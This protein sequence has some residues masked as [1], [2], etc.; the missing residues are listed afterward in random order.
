MRSFSPPEWLV[1]WL[2]P[3]LAV[4]AEGALL[5]VIY[6]AIET[7]V[8][9]RVPLLGTFEFAVAAGLAAVTVRRGWIDPDASVMPFLGLLL[10]L[11]VIGW[12]WDASVR[13]LV[14]AGDLA[15]AITRHPG[16]WL[17]VVAGMRGIGRGL[18]IDDRAL[19]RL[20]LV[21]VP[22]LA[23]PWTFGQVASGELRPVFT[24]HAFIAS[25]TFVTTGFIAAG[26][27]RL[28]EIGRETGVDW[29]TNR[30]WL[31]TVFGVLVVVLALGYPAAL[32]LGLPGDAVARGVLEP[33]LS[34]FG[35]ALAIIAGT[36]LFVAALLA[37]MLRQAGLSFQ[38]GEP[39][40]PAAVLEQ[41]PAYTIEQ[42]RGP[43]I[44]VVALWL[45]VLVVGLVL[46]RVWLRRRARSRSH[47]T[48]EERSF[49]IPR[50]S[51]R[52]RRGRPSPV[53]RATLRGPRPTDA[54]TA[55][56]AALQDLAATAPGR[57]R[58]EH[59]TPRAHARR[60]MAGSELD[61]LQADYALARYGE[62]RLT[63]AENR[64]AVGR[65]RRLRGRL[66]TQA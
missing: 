38:P 58:A 49:Q 59:E 21:G 53:L 26:L 55:Y 36:A 54:V 5:G 11:G 63:D 30:S 15:G 65:W 66:R 7:T 20:V 13:E 64:R 37:S 52:V 2:L 6:V 4:V 46:V 27:A 62:R 24:E 28:Q 60:V 57:G 61:A 23:I 44:G 10:G 35:Y 16:G 43:I 12:A 41:I 8:D 34:V 42:L 50:G 9:S 17:M 14:L 29:R 51:Q 31:G 48:T 33:I 18:E 22:A 56:L 39:P 40:A 3:V 47:G 45:A 1:G 25:L 19:T 32:L